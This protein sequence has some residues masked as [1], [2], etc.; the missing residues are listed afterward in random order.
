LPPARLWVLP[1]RA[2]PNSLLNFMVVSWLVVHVL[3]VDPGRDMAGEGIRSQTKYPP[4]HCPGKGIRGERR[5]GFPTG[6]RD[7]NPDSARAEPL[8]M[9]DAIPGYVLLLERE[10]V[11]PSLPRKGIAENQQ[12]G[13]HREPGVEPGCGLCLLADALPG[14][15]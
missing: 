12:A 11:P 7:S 5:A 2:R 8:L 15:S 3:L 9:G 6:G 1:W 14:R 4:P 13:F 10:E